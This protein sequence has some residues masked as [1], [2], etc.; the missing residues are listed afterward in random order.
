MP[1]GGTQGFQSFGPKG[2]VWLSFNANGEC[3]TS[4][5]HVSHLRPWVGCVGVKG[6]EASI[7]SRVTAPALVDAAPD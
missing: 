2:I 1:G 4:L 5:A 6:V 3:V 7:S